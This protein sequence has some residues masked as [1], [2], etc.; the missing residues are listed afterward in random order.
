M[1]CLIFQ[2]ILKP[3]IQECVIVVHLL[4]IQEL[5]LGNKLFISRSPKDKRIVRDQIRDKVK[6]DL[7]GY[8]VGGCKYANLKTI[9]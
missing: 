6:I 5:K 7:K 2:W 9:I 3:E 4:L 1:E 8:L